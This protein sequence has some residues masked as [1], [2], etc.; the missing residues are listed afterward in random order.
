MALQPVIR[1]PDAET[2]T[3]IVT[4]TLGAYLSGPAAAGTGA[5]NTSPQV[6]QRSRSI[7]YPVA[8]ISR[9]PSKRRT[10]ALVF[11]ARTAPWAQS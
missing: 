8:A 5:V 6:S 1:N 11:W 10:I 3:A 4:P 2:K 7:R 9:E